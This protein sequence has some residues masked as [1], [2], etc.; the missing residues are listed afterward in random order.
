MFIW[1]ASSKPLDAILFAAI[2]IDNFSAGFAGTILIAYMSS[3]VSRHYVATDYAL[4]SSLFTLPGRLLGGV[5]GQLVDA[6]GYE[7]FFLLTAL[8]GIPVCLLCLVVPIT[9]ERPTMVD[10]RTTLPD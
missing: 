4:L 6:F 9:K 10:A 8:F 3:L 1:L 5:S 2:S 7:S